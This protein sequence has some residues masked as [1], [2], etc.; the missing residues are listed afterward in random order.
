MKWH[1]NTVATAGAPAAA[2]RSNR[3]SRNRLAQL[4][5]RVLG[6]LLTFVVTA[7]AAGPTRQFSSYL[8]SGGDF[9]QIQAV[10]MDSAGNSYVTGF[11]YRG[12]TP[13]GDN[14]DVIVARF[15][16][17][18]EMLYARIFGQAKED[19]GFGI[20]VDEAGNAYVAGQYQWTQPWPGDGKVYDQSRVFVAKFDPAGELL[21][22]LP[23]GRIDGTYIAAARGLARDPRTGYLYLTGEVSGNNIVDPSRNFPITASAFQ[24]GMASASTEGFLAVIDLATHTL[25]YSTY[26]GA[27]GSSVA[28]DAQGNAYVTGKTLAGIQTTPG[29]IQPNPVGYW[30]AFVIKVNP[31]AFGPASLVYATYLGGSRYDEGKSIVVDTAGNAHVAGATDSGM[32]TGQEPDAFPTTPSAFQRLFGGGTCSPD[33][34]VSGCSDA[35]L[36]KLDPMASTIVYSTLIGGVGGDSAR[37]VA[38]GSNGLAYLTGNATV[39]FPV[40]RQA[41][42]P[43]PGDGSDAFL[44]VVD[45]TQSNRASLVYASFMGGDAHDDGYAIAVREAGST[46]TVLLGGVTGSTDFPVFRAVQPAKGLG[47]DAFLAVQSALGDLAGGPAVPPL[48]I[49]RTPGNRLHVIWENG[50]L[51]TAPDVTGPWR[52]NASNS[53]FVLEPA[54]PRLFFRVRP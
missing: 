27:P 11:A 12:T 15:S 35:F 19:K 22:L 1:L 32:I 18:G 49:Q 2:S 34:P 31:A 17:T 54:G 40:T 50:I 26:L 25:V 13:A 28:V 38:I 8:D 10:T 39:R 3:P 37:S 45:T 42:Q 23:V 52:P 29:V 21:E 7:S 20:V 53:P 47:W 14:F 6:M 46:T 43:L 36:A 33:G 41:A 24:P 48:T 5:A 44:A 4:L 51:E 30:D 9:D 16:P